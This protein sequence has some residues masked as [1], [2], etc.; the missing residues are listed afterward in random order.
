[1][2]EKD[3]QDEQ[4][5]GSIRVVSAMR[6]DGDSNCFRMCNFRGRCHLRICN[7]TEST[8]VFLSISQTWTTSG[9]G[10]GLACRSNLIDC[11][12]LWTASYELSYWWSEFHNNKDIWPLNPQRARI[13]VRSFKGTWIAFKFQHLQ[14]QRLKCSVCAEF[15]WDRALQNGIHIIFLFLTCQF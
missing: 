1:M 12:N 7:N 15:C 6:K 3:A 14:N 10:K 8:V 9:S 2:A 13:E 4:N 5:T 11:S